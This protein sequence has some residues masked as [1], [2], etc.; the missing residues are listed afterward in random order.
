M[1]DETDR[2]RLEYAKKRWGARRVF[3]AIVGT[4]VFVL[5]IILVPLPGPGLVVMVLGLAILA[6]EFVWA[7]RAKRYVERKARETARRAKRRRE[8]AYLDVP[9]AH[10]GRETDPTHLPR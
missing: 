5:G 10:A 7:W 4:A 9:D 6:S 8:T 3:I 2:I 1:G